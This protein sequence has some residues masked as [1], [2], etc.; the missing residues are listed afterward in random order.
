[1]KK[2]V[3]TDKNRGVDLNLTLKGGRT[4][5][6]AEVGDPKGKPLFLFHGLHSSRLEVALI[7]EKMKENNIRVIAIDRVGVGRSTFRENHTLFDTVDDVVELANSLGIEKFSVLGTSSGAKYALACAYKI[8]MRLNAVFCLSSGVP[9]E[10]FNDDMPTANR[11]ML[12]FLQKAP[13]LIKPIFWLSFARISQDSKK[14][15]TFLGNIIYQ[16]DNID[17]ELLANNPEIKK[18]FAKQCRESYLQGAKGNSSDAQIDMLENGWGF[19]LEEI[20]F[21]PIYAWHG[22]LDRGI[23]L[24]IAKVLEERVKGIEFKALEGE[25][26]LTLVFEVLDEVIEKVDSFI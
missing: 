3:I 15:D 13:W 4:L 9:I 5:S 23:P 26:H 17:K 16:L 20:D 21:S 10:F 14:V 22:S 7:D 8:P 18:Q 25:G 19:K 11:V 24:S 1:M 6:Y 12:K 2:V